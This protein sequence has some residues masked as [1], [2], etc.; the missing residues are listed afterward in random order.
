MKSTSTP[1]QHKVLAVRKQTKAYINL[2]RVR[3]QIQKCSAYLARWPHPW[4]LKEVASNESQ[5]EEN[6]EDYMSE[7]QSAI[8]RLFLCLYGKL[9][10]LSKSTW[11][12]RGFH[13]EGLHIHDND[14]FDS[15]DVLPKRRNAILERLDYWNQKTNLKVDKSFEVLNKTISSQLN[16]F[17]ENTSDYLK[18]A[19]PTNLPDNVIGYDLLKEK[20]GPQQCRSA[21]LSELYNDQERTK[22]KSATSF[23]VVDL[24]VRSY[25]KT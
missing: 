23:D 13:T 14:P 20:L 5:P 12:R 18:Q 1:S 3:L 24:L 9:N 2:I 4:L 21:I 6:T 7:L 8:G 16:Y 25:F 11:Y 22:K 15:I 19:H 17:L 10:S